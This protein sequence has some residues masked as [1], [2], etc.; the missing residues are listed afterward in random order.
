MFDF[1]DVRGD[2]KPLSHR[3]GDR[4]RR[5]LVEHVGNDTIGG[6]FFD[7]RGNRARR[8]QFHRV[9]YFRHAMVERAAEYAGKRE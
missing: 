5:A 4:Y 8:L 7:E 1:R 2:R 3:L 6:R 9:G